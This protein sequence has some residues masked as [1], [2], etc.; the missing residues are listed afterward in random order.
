MNFGKVLGRLIGLSA[1]FATLLLAAFYGLGKTRL[2]HAHAQDAQTTTTTTGCTLATVKGS[3]GYL[4]NGTSEYANASLGI[5]QSDGKGKWTF[6]QTT[7][8]ESG[9]FMGTG[10]GTYTLDSNCTGTMKAKYVQDGV[11]YSYNLVM[12][13]VGNANQIDFMSTT[14]PQGL[15]GVATRIN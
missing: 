12:V 7:V 3:Y 1:I 14:P 13:V 6:S 11:T 10:S 4:A 8:S 2:V 9:T 5:I 15:T